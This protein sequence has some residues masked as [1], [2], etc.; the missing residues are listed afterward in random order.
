MIAETIPGLA[1]LSSDD[2]MLLAAELWQQ[3]VG[4]DAH[5]PDPVLVNV[6]R[7]RLAHYHAHPEEVSSWEEVCRRIAA[8][9]RR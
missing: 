2:K 7:E 6:L 1:G 5:T 4:S 9:R 3:A 8:L